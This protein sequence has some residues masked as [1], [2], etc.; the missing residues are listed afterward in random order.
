[1]SHALKINLFDAEEFQFSSKKKSIEEFQKIIWRYYEHYQRRFLWREKLH[2]YHVVVSEI[3]LQQTQ[4]ERVS[5]KFASFIELFPDFFSLAQAPFNEVLREWKGLGYNRRAMNLQKIAG[6]VTEQYDGILPKSIATLETFPGIGKA[7]ARSIYTFAF[8]E[9]T[10]FIETNI[11]SVFLHFFFKDETSKISDRSI[12]VLVEKYLDRA[13]PREWYYALMDFGAMLKKNLGNPNH[14][15]AHYKKQ[16]SFVG[17]N[18]QLRGK[19]LQFLLTNRTSS[20]ESLQNTFSED[21]W[22]FEPILNQLCLEGLVK[23]KSGFYFL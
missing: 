8:D 5:K 19:I 17:S 12:E 4:T 2:P 6:L 1:M 11:R 15:S 10:V 13:Q 7:T 16:S 21:A 9:P 3:M 20:L 23:E 18:R 22:R 14:Q